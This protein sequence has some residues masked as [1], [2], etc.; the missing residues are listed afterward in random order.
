MVQYVVGAVLIVAAIVTSGMLVL[1]YIRGIDLPGCGV[2]RG[3]SELT[4]GKWGRIGTWPVSHVGF[5]YF[6]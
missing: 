2:G 5:A 6:L 1:S 3:C 4:S